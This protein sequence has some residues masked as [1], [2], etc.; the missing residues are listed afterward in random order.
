MA[1]F[2]SLRIVATTYLE[3]T[4]ELPVVHE[5]VVVKAELPVDY[6]NFN[7]YTPHPSAA[8]R[9]ANSPAPRIRKSRGS[10]SR[11]STAEGVWPRWG[12][13]RHIV[14]VAAIRQAFA[15]IA[16]FGLRCSCC[17]ACRWVTG[18]AWRICFVRKC[19]ALLSDLGS[20]R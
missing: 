12:Q 5:H 7:F 20:N 15:E 18:H 16:S 6:A 13:R 9:R 2:A 14:H 17:A 11:G 19:L 1:P 3:V 4:V 10:H 8:T